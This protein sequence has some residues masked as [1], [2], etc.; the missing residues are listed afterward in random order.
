MKK[1]LV[2]VDFSENA[3]TAALYAVELARTI[4]YSTH[5]IHTYLPFSSS[6]AGEKLNEEL[7]EIET[8]MA[9][10]N[11]LDFEKRLKEKSADA[12]I[13]SSCE[14]GLLSEVV[15]KMIND[16]EFPL[17]VMGTK[18]AS[19]LKY[20]VL[21]SNTFD[22]IK[23][24]SVPVLAIPEVELS[25]QLVRVGLL[26]NFKASEI[27][28]L[29]SYISIFGKPKTLVLFHILEQDSKREE[30]ELNNWAKEIKQ[31]TGIEQIK[32]LS[33]QMVGRLDVKED[34]PS[35]IFSITES[36][37]LGVLLV[38]KERKTFTSKLFSRNL[39]K[40]LAHQIKS[41]IFFHTN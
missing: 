22:I 10:E 41:P 15:L 19:G 8:A 35:S 17:I 23:K 4:G 20:A 34:F 6:F 38:T 28:V 13:T 26:T 16:E 18:G 30:I 9:E 33:E 2:P 14:S 32:C 24:S 3:M 5:L 39:V 7:F 29:E 1:I 40:A 36:Q 21:G 27:E 12:D 31:R 11:M 37:D 25:P